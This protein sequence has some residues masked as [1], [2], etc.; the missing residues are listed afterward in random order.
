MEN[1]SQNSILLNW[2]GDHSVGLSTVGA[3]SATYPRGYVLWI[4][5]HADLN[6]PHV[7]PTG[8]LHGMPLSILLNLD[9]SRST[10][11]PWIRK[12]LLPEKLIYIGARDLDAFEVETIKNL[13]IKIIPA[14]E[15]RLL[16]MSTIAQE[17]Y[18]IVADDPLHIS[19]DIDSVSPDLAPSTGVPSLKGLE[20]Q[21]LNELAKI[22]SKHKEIKS[23]DV[24][25][26]NP[27]IGNQN[28]VAQTYKIAFNFLT[29]LFQGEKNDWI[30]NKSDQKLNT[31]T[32][33]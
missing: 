18:S 8:N 26:I 25:E 19:F 2:G 6:L 22:I 30:I 12:S 14:E 23:V 31:T 3:F 17:I 7:S 1:L 32:M 29:L 33:E 16:G 21:D 5:A 10:Y 24:V 9:D 13:N 27:K 28:D 20:I 11:L 15:V 4:D